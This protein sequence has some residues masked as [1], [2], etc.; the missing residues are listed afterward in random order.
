MEI[1]L[2][3]FKSIGICLIT[4]FLVGCAKEELGLKNQ[5]STEMSKK[6]T[7]SKTVLKETT[8]SETRTTE[9]VQSTEKIVDEQDVSSETIA[10]LSDYFKSEYTYFTKIYDMYEEVKAANDDEVKIDNIVKLQEIKVGDELYGVFKLTNSFFYNDGCMED[11]YILLAKSLDDGQTW[12]EV[13]GELDKLHERQD[14]YVFT[15]EDIIELE[16]NLINLKFSFRL[17]GYDG[18]I[19]PIGSP[20]F[21]KD[22]EKSEV[23][24]DCG[25][26]Y[27]YGDYWML[28]TYPNME[29]TSYYSSEFDKFTINTVATQRKDMMTYNGIKIGDSRDKVVDTYSKIEGF[30]NIVDS[31]NALAYSEDLQGLGANMTFEFKDEKVIKIII[32]NAFD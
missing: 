21:L 27:N 20:D 8:V 31:E 15:E 26:I 6:T 24:D 23:L 10:L 22:E 7:V 32:Y 3:S 29:V 28:H 19:G 2:R 13:I 4:L 17:D 14:G 12:T 9:I 5:S 11:F 25:V 1:K 18:L 16:N 30:I